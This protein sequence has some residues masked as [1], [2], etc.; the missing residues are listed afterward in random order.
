MAVRLRDGI[1]KVEGDSGDRTLTVEYDAA[2]TN[3]DEIRDAL[4]QAGYPA[5]SSL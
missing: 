1:E 4:E 3:P 2:A 5:E